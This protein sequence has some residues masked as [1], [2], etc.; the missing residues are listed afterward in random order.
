MGQ[1]QLTIVLIRLQGNVHWIWHMKIID[2]LS[3]IVWVQKP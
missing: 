3:K 2:N 1:T